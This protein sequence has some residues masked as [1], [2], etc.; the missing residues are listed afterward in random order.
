MWLCFC[1][2]QESSQP[3]TTVTS[4]SCPN[5]LCATFSILLPRH[6]TKQEA[7]ARNNVDRT[8][9]YKQYLFISVVQKICYV[10]R[11]DGE[12]KQNCTYLGDGKDNHYRETGREGSRTDWWWRWRRLWETSRPGL[13][14]QPWKMM[15]ECLYINGKSDK[16]FRS[17]S[18]AIHFAINL[19][20]F[21]IFV[22]P[23]FCVYVFIV[24]Y[25]R[26]QSECS[27]FNAFLAALPLLSACPPS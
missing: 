20:I 10:R 12:D 19:T 9:V 6:V 1:Y 15:K 16:S 7:N 25:V 2:R 17:M 3:T 27:L 24:S 8:R 26:L 14:S 13:I 22:G 18:K 5:L 23:F 11:F 4:H 21:H